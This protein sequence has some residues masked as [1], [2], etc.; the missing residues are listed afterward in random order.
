MNIEQAEKYIKDTVKIYLSK[1]KYGEYEIP[2]VRQRPIFLLGAPGIG[3]TAIL[4]QT[5][6]DLGINLVSYSMTHHTRQSALG[7]PF[8][9]KRSYDGEEYSV[10]E[11]TMSEII[12]SMYE[13]MEKSK[14]K[15]GILFLD[16]INCVSETLAPA[17]LQFLQQ[18]VFGRHKI[19]DGWVIVT[20]GNP[21]EYNKSVREFDIAT[22]D[23]LKVIEVE[24][25]FD[26]W[27]SYALKRDVHGAI[28]NFLE[29]NRNYFYKIETLGGKQTYVTARGWEDL[30]SVIKLY[31]KENIYADE[32]L[33]GQYIKNDRIAGEFS[34][35]YDL[36]M[37]YKKKYN[38]DEILSGKWS[39]ELISNAKSASFE[40]KL[41]LT[42][43]I[44]GELEKEMSENMEETDVLSDVTKVIKGIINERAEEI[45]ENIIANETYK[46]EMK[47]KGLE[48]AG[49]LSDEEKR[50]QKRVIYILK[51]IQ[52][53]L[54]N[55]DDK[56][57]ETV[58]RM[59]NE[60]IA[61]AK[62]DNDRVRD[63]VHNAFLFIEETFGTGNEL[64]VFVTELT[65][66]PK[67]AAFIG[68]FASEDYQKYS[69][70]L[71]IN[72]RRIEL[73]EDIDKALEEWKETD[74]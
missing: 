7:L 21:P 44:A 55:T 52:E 42:G 8:I 33:I 47:L 36:Y 57:F 73:K 54:I 72:E 1:D 53:A 5:A 19:P 39:E 2:L 6:Q 58:K 22:K 43:I 70:E 40:E 24:A 4:E 49:A 38:T 66:N 25:D 64:T 62:T 50:K 20:A 61:S 16:E 13:V 30:S 28:I 27:K 14:I 23:R 65:V 41:S 74:D 29:A 71:L 51:E 26:V 48:A 34:A 18:K 56:D 15:E 45:P 9:E 63:A 32:T 17:M 3:K 12:S 67:S 46:K 31:E 60:R 35:Y 69:S 11:Y 68:R 10:T 59:F 37:K